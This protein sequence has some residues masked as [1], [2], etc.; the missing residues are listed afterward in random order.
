MTDRVS[1]QTSIEGRRVGLSDDGRLVLNLDNDRQIVIGG[2]LNEDQAAALARLLPVSAADNGWDSLPRALD[3]LRFIPNFGSSAADTTVATNAGATTV[4][5]YDPQNGNDANNGT[6]YLLA[7]KTLPTTTLTTATKYLIKAGSTLT[8]DFSAISQRLLLDANDITISVYDPATGNE[9]TTQPNPFTRALTGGWVTA[10]ELATKYFKI[11]G[12]SNSLTR[13]QHS[14]GTAGNGIVA[15]GSRTGLLIRGAYITGCGY[16]AVRLYSNARVEDC[17]IQDSWSKLTSATDNSPIG[18]A[19]RVDA[20]FTGPSVARLF[21]ERTGEDTFYLVFTG[22]TGAIDPAFSDCAIRGNGYK[23]LTS[24][25][26]ADVWQT[27]TYPGDYSIK[28]CVVENMLPNTVISNGAGTS[29]VGSTWQWGPSSG[30]DANS[31]DT[32]GTIQDVIIAT[33]TNAINGS[34]QSGQNRTR[35]LIYVERDGGNSNVSPCNENAV[36]TYTDTCIVYANPASASDT[37]FSGSAPT[38]TRVTEL[39]G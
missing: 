15:G 24:D 9:I 10:T 28:R 27:R 13:A 20:A 30:T 17:V 26:H 7:K 29:P 35:C 25:T 38:K 4:R 1:I 2:S 23:V 39:R 33:N 11:E 12:N 19:I 34:A 36:Q 14:G 22:A 3:W 37:T 18:Q 8:A 21:V 16:S 5:Y 6:T 32:G 31:A